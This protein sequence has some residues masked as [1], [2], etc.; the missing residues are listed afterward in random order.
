[1]RKEK[2]VGKGNKEKKGGAVGR[3]VGQ[4]GCRKRE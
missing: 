1:M 3:K 4:V 2:D